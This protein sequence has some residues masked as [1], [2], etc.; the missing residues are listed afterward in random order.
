MSSQPQEEETFLP[1]YKHASDSSDATEAP[2]MHLAASQLTMVFI[3]RPEKNLKRKHI[4]ATP[5]MRETP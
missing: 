2:P 5:A 1:E 3:L 4:H